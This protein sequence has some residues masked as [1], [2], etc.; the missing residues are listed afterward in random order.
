MSHIQT[1][2]ALLLCTTLIGSG[3][4]LTVDLDDTP[5]LPQPAPTATRAD[6]RAFDQ[7]VDDLRFASRTSTSALPTG[8]VTYDG[9][10]GSNLRLNGQDGYGMLGDLRMQVGFGSGD[11]DGSVRNIN[12]LEN[13]TPIQRFG[14]QLTINGEEYAG[15]L[16]ADADGILSLVTD[17]GRLQRT[18]MA[19]DLTGDV[20]NDVFVGDAV[21][22]TATGF[23]DG[24][25]L[26]GETFN[27]LLDNGGSFVGTVD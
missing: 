23:G 5:G 27:V 10:L 24:Y 13:G 16:V 18:N 11:I 25:Q 20:V 3:G 15:R 14:G 7:Q 21:V 19:L 12:L 4:S 6:V 9:Q 8:T 1:P 2:V 22:G 26:T 17:D